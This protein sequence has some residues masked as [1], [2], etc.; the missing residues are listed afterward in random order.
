MGYIRIN[1]LLLLL[2][3]LLL[4]CIAKFHTR[5]TL[6]AEESHYNASM[7]NF[8]KVVLWHLIFRVSCK[9]LYQT[10]NTSRFFYSQS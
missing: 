7:P 3:L 5:Y 9:V 8:A 4:K 10:V 2:L 6:F 1:L